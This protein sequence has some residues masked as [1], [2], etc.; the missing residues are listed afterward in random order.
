MPLHAYA[1]LVRRISVSFC[2]DS[3]RRDAMT[4]LLLLL[5]TPTRLNRARSKRTRGKLLRA[6]MKTRMMTSSSY[7][8]SRIARSISFKSGARRRLH[9]REL[10]RVH[11]IA[12]SDCSF[13][14]RSTVCMGTCAFLL[15]AHTRIHIRTCISTSLSLSLS[16]HPAAVRLRSVRM[17]VRVCTELVRSVCVSLCVSACV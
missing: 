7:T 12:F 5:P 13:Q 10:L 6:T 8:S 9:Q 2:V 17:C 4:L 15:L 1:W 16:L 14:R 11:Q 3:C